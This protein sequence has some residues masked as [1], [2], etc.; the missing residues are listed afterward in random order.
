MEK[1]E[2]TF[3]FQQAKNMKGLLS[4]LVFITDLDAHKLT[5]TIYYYISKLTYGYILLGFCFL[6]NKYLKLFQ[7]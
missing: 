7:G 3:N 1:K 6:L 5:K 2:N 4:T